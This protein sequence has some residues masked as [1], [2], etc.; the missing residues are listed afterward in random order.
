MTWV[1]MYGRAYTLHIVK[2]LLYEIRL[3]N[4]LAKKG[5]EAPLGYL[6]Q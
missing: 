5:V 2:F 3:V 1:A 6:A 4:D